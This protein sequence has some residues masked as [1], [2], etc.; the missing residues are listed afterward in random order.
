M[1]RR[2]FLKSTTGAA[3][4]TAAASAAAL[5]APAVVSSVRELTMA[6]AWPDGVAGLADQ[7]FRLARRIET[8]TDGRYRIT[9]LP[10]AADGPRGS[11]DLVHASAHRH[12]SHHPAFAYFAGL[13]IASG[14]SPAALP[15]WLASGGQELWDDLSADLGER[16]LLVG[17]TG[18]ASWLWSAAPIAGADDLV[19]RRIAAV[20]LGRDIVGALGGLA[21]DVA[22]ADLA[23]ALRSRAADAVEWCGLMCGSALGLDR[24]EAHVLGSALNP[25][26]MAVSLG[27]SRKVWDAMPDA[28]RTLLEAIAASEH[29]ESLAEAQAIDAMVHAAIAPAATPPDLASTIAKLAD[30]IVADVAGRDATSMRVD[31]SYMAFAKSLGRG[32]GAAASA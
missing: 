7:A 28:D 4:A 6:T 31:A 18:G 14:L 1:D 3:A 17:H 10:G 9:I 27:V 5:A 8:A 19:G 29:R 22:P 15:L 23:H 16:S 13:P 12:L 32:V 30:A 2:Q 25:H 20:G 21:V 24:V 11:Y 26:G